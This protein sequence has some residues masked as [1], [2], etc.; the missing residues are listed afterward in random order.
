MG[1]ISLAGERNLSPRTPTIVC[2][3]SCAWYCRL[4][5]K[6]TGRSAAPDGIVGRTAPVSSSA[7]RS[8]DHYT[9][10]SAPRRPARTVRPAARRKEPTLL[11]RER[12]AAA[13]SIDLKPQL[14][15]LPPNRALASPAGE[16]I[17][18]P[19]P[20]WRFAGYGLRTGR[21]NPIGLHSDSGFDGSPLWP[22][23][24]RCVMETTTPR[25][26]LWPVATW[27]PCRLS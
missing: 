25:N 14:E 20:C 6:R 9:C 11:L 23:N 2:G 5:R 26:R 13:G 12:H 4:I 10:A 7:R 19:P 17:A 18:Q 24:R 16:R 21:A 27:P 1:V 15:I 8:G 3:S 22:S